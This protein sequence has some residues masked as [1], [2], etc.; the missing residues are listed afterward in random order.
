MPINVNS[1]GGSG[2]VIKVAKKPGMESLSLLAEETSA[3]SAKPKD[4]KKPTLWNSLSKCVCVCVW[5]GG[6]GGG[7][8]SKQDYG[9]HL[10]FISVVD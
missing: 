1:F 5:G 6:G 4:K 9:V 3:E 10:I 2:A 8:M 7:G